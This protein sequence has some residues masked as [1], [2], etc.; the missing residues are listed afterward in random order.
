MATTTKKPAAKKAAKP[1]AKPPAK[2]AATKSAPKATAKRDAGLWRDRIV[3]VQRLRVGDILPHPLQ[4]KTHPDKQKEMLQSNLQ[5]TGKVDVLRAYYSERNQGR[6][7]FFDGHGRRGL[8]PDEIWHVAICDLSDAEADRELHV[9]DAITGYAQIE[10]E[11]LDRLLREVG[12]GEAS[13]QALLADLAQEAGLYQDEPPEPGDGGDE[14]DPEAAAIITRCQP[15]DLWLI[16]GHGLTH[17]L[18]CGDSTRAEDVERV[19]GGARAKVCFTD[20]PW[21]VAI[22]KDSNPRHRQRE[23]LANDDL[24]PEQFRAF[25]QGF[26]QPLVKVLE[27]DLY[28]VL[29]ASEWPTLDRCLRDEGFHW[30][31]TV[32]W[33]KDQFVLGRSKYHR[34]YEP[35]WYGWHGKSKSSFSPSAGRDKDDVWEIARPRV[36]AEHPTMKPVELVERAVQYSSEPRDIVYEPFGGSGTTLIASHRTGRQARLLEIEPK[37]CDVI[38]AR[39]EAEGLTVRRA[40]SG[41]PTSA[42]KKRA[43]ANR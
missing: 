29:G 41:T 30:S 34:R 25:L 16:E 42:R 43:A 5:E 39:A 36:S 17:R 14:F 1:A 15:G 8:A 23:G 32:I 7:T 33:V 10:A 19:M 38:L 31:A 13:L 40:Q 12:T 27:G 26:M 18:L 35:I 28:C 24:T 6:L 9:F 3:E 20:P 21:N 37:Y 2:K 4:H 11:A 22:G